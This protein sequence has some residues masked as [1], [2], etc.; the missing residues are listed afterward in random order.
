MEMKNIKKMIQDLDAILEINKESIE[1]LVERDIQL[2]NIEIMS[3]EMVKMAHKFK[4][5]STE[6]RKK[7]EPWY[8]RY[9]YSIGSA[10]VTLLTL[11]L[12]L[13]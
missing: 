1:C 13:L 9:Q 8:K 12:Y 5:I 10:S 6:L 2:T 11:V 7:E 3:E 4:G